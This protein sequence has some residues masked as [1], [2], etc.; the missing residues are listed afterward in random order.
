MPRKPSGEFDQ[1]QYIKDY[2]K[3]NIIYRKMNFNRL[4]QDDM[5]IVSWLD[6]QPEGVSNYLKRLIAED[7]KTQRNI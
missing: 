3:A 5:A 7:I 2:A 6:S 4:K 1:K